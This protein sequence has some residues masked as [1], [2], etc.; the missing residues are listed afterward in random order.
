MKLERAHAEKAWVEEMANRRGYA[1]EL[2]SVVCRFAISDHI[3]MFCINTK[4]PDI[5]SDDP[6]MC[7][8]FG[9]AFVRFL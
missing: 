5:L 8:N 4:V 6:E 9:V 3:S 2:A 7:S 1:D